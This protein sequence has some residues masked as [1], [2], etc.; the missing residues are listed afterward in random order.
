M[1]RERGRGKFSGCLRVTHQD[2][3]PKLS[4]VCP[5]PLTATAAFV[6]VPTVCH[7][8][9]RPMKSLQNDDCDRKQQEHA[10]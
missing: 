1:D 10:G 4:A 7:C 8:V 2:V 6:L 9:E 5:L 3:I